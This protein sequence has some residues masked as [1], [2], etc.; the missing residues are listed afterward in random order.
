MI[1]NGYVYSD[2]WED[3]RFMS[4]EEENLVLGAL[5]NLTDEV[6]AHGIL[7]G[8]IGDRLDDV[9]RRLNS[10]R[11]KLASMPE[12][13]RVIAEAALDHRELD[14]NRKQRKFLANVLVL[15]VGGAGGTALWEAWLRPWLHK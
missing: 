14:H 12:D 9:D 10:I 13:S 6:R 2:P 15:I 1:W 5:K 8:R 11:P 4:G 3:E 7:L